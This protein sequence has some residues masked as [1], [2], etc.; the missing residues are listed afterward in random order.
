MLEVSGFVAPN[1]VV[2]VGNMLNAAALTYV[3]AT[4]VALAQF[5]RFLSYRG[6]RN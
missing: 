5:L 6:R 2:L 1:E 3:A 4:A